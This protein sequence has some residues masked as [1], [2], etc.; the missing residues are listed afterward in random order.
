MIA[1]GTG[2]R[3]W[4]LLGA[5]WN[6]RGGDGW[7]IPWQTEKGRWLS[8]GGSLAN[9]QTRRADTLGLRPAAGIAAS[10]PITI[11]L[12]LVTA[13]IAPIRPKWKY[14]Q[15]V[16]CIS[17]LWWLVIFW[18]LAIFGYTFCSLF[19]LA[20]VWHLCTES[21]RLSNPFPSP[22]LDYNIRATMCNKAG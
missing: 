11:I 6:L 14:S 1:L 8:W 16:G 5:G 17:A 2:G 15:T 22:A 13:A 18:L 10:P 9:F 3:L 7:A 21:A 4:G 12:N 19:V 20:K